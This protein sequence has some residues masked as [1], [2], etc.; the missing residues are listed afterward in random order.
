MMLKSIH[1]K[2]AIL[3]AVAVLGMG[4]L[5]QAHTIFFDLDG[6]FSAYHGNPNA[7]ADIVAPGVTVD[8]TNFDY[9]YAATLAAG[10]GLVS[11]DFFTVYDFGS[12]VGVVSTPA[13]WTVS[14]QNP[15]ITPGTQ[16][17]P[18]G[19]LQ[20]VTF[21]YTGPGIGSVLF[22][23]DLGQFVLQSGNG[24][25]SGTIFYSGESNEI[26]PPGIS[27]NTDTTFGPSDSGA[28]NP[29]PMP[30]SVWG[31]LGMLAILGAGKLVRRRSLLA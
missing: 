22:N 9:H 17:P 30:A 12:L 6:Q 19:P 11:G 15:G 8:G 21:T 1:A 3:S 16:V 28:G 2:A 27:D 29:A 20:N 4:S 14:T 31:G 10:S 24:T 7:A 5:A 25:S 18:D 26:N 23:Q 13:D